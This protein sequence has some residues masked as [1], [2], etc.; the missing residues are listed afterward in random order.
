MR[1]PEDKAA[2]ARLSERVSKACF[3]FLLS[4]QWTTD[5][6]LG[7]SLHWLTMALAAVVGLAFAPQLPS[8]LYGL[9]QGEADASIMVIGTLAILTMA[10]LSHQFHRPRL[11]CTWKRP[12]DVG[13]LL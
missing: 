13:E 2:F 9:W 10:Y 11:P 12:S 3:R 6:L 1:L 5:W 7:W 8:T 4:W